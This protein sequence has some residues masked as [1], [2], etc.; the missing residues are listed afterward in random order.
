MLWYFKLVE[1]CTKRRRIKI[2]KFDRVKIAIGIILLLFSVPSLALGST[3]LYNIGS[4]SELGM[5]PATSPTVTADTNNSRFFT[6]W[7]DGRDY[8]WLI[9]SRLINSSGT[10]Y[11]TS[12]TKVTAASRGRYQEYS[13]VSAFDSRNSRFLTAWTE[14][15]SNPPNTYVNG[16]IYGRVLNADGSILSQEIAIEGNGL[17]TTDVHVAYNSV[18]NNYLVV[19]T[20][21]RAGF[22]GSSNIYARLVNSDGSLSGK[23]VTVPNSAVNASGASVA[24]NENLNRFFVT[25]ID[26]RS[27]YWGVYGR[28]LSGSTPLGSTDTEI[29]A[30]EDRNTFY[31]Q[32]DF[33]KLSNRFLV[34]WANSGG[35]GII[36]RLVNADGALYGTNFVI[37]SPGNLA[38]NPSLAAD[39]VNGRFLVSWLNQAGIN[40]SLNARLVSS[41]GSS[42]N[43]S[44]IIIFWGGYTKRPFQ[45]GNALAFDKV[46]Q[47]FISVF[48]DTNGHSFYQLLG[49]T[50]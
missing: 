6:A 26:N 40:Q 44:D 31:T 42:L 18:D 35:S 37:S 9:F 28:F 20:G 38:L 27:G 10:L 41:D 19:W 32:V 5:F 12:D 22:A 48:D 16:D 15:R 49:Y 25:W 45:H 21:Y 13:P 23:I 30:R 2:Y 29:G 7:M 33:D 50:P 8:P 17:D 4:P 47:R 36:G 24:Y 1:G 14:Y 11:G 39:S 34:V 43:D 46:S 3:S